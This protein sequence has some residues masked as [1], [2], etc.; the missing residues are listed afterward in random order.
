MS[1]T[2]VKMIC[3]WKTPSDIVYTYLLC[4][5][6]SGQNDKTGLELLHCRK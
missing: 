2:A 4:S 3:H 1:P 6:L 5:I